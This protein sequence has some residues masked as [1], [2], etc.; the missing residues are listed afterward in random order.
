MERPVPAVV[1]HDVDDV[2]D[3]PVRPR[4]PAAGRELAA[5]NARLV[6][7]LEPADMNHQPTEILLVEGTVGIG[8]RRL[9]R[10]PAAVRVGVVPVEMD[11]IDHIRQ[12]DGR[13]IAEG[14]GGARLVGGEHDRGH[15]I[16]RADL[17]RGPLLQR[18]VAPLAGMLLLRLV[19]QVVTVDDVVIALQ[20][21]RRMPPGVKEILGELGTAEDALGAEG[22]EEPA[23]HLVHVDDDHQA[24]LTRPGED[25]RHEMIQGFVQPQPVEAPPRLPRRIAVG[26]AE[27]GMPRPELTER[28]MH[29]VAI[30]PSAPGGERAD[31]ILRHAQ[32]RRTHR[33]A[34]DGTPGDQVVIRTDQ[35]LVHVRENVL[36][37]R[38]LQRRQVEEHAAGGPLKTEVQRRAP[39]GRAAP[40]DGE[41]EVRPAEC[42]GRTDLARIVGFGIGRHAG[43]VVGP[44]QHE[45]E[46][47]LPDDV[48]AAHADRETDRV[49]GQRRRI[50]LGGRAVHLPG[51]RRP[52]PHV[53]DDHAAVHP[54]R[55]RH[56]PRQRRP[57][58][59]KDAPG[60]NQRHHNQHRAQ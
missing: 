11:L 34:E 48:L 42:A 40:G 30:E 35:V 59:P 4:R 36:A 12:V 39:D 52:R 26:Q 60:Q 37:R 9:R 47:A 15:R 49:S 41:D 56:L 6:L 23:G 28:R 22:L 21:R 2:G 54:H 13:E 10:G 45:L 55:L 5:E 51:R 53:R 31:V 44:R 1:L 19:H 50:D 58:R 24:V 43:R 46:S 20:A 16:D 3:P 33:P 17:P 27:A 57:V 29:L 38:D 18:P 14:L 25:V 8:P 32:R 7:L